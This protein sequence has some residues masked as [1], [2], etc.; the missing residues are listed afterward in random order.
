MTEKHGESSKL[1]DL[2]HFTFYGSFYRVIDVIMF[3][4]VNLIEFFSFSLKLNERSD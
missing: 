2:L 1:K 4:K 3:F